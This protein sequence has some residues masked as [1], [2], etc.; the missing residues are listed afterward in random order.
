MKN[1]GYAFITAK[2]ISDDLAERGITGKNGG[3]ISASIIGRHLKTLGLP[4]KAKKIDGKTQKV[5][6]DNP[7]ILKLLKEK[8]VV[9]EEEETTT[10][11]MLF[12]DN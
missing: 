1:N 5:V 7:K 9:D 2:L 6:S 3:N 11:E 4:T 12:G 10:Q 8:Y